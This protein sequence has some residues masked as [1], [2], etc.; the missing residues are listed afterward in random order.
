MRDNSGSAASRHE[1][2]YSKLLLM[3]GW[4]RVET[5]SDEIG[6][7][8]SWLAGDFCF[9]G[10]VY[11]VSSVSIRQKRI[12]RSELSP[13]WGRRWNVNSIQP[14]LYSVAESQQVDPVL[15][16]QILLD[17]FECK[18]H[19]HLPERPFSVSYFYPID[20]DSSEEKVSATIKT[21]PERSFSR[22]QMVSETKLYSDE[23]QF[24]SPME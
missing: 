9:D 16:S 12:P 1:L 3:S 18:R 7:P 23:Y 19:Q 5:G 17:Q 22:D 10:S 4:Q 21:C 20:H 14:A 24:S 11:Y 6:P 8:I 13:S 15:A 2:G